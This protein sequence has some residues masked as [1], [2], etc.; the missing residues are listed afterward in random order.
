MFGLWARD[1]GT[2]AA[3]TAADEVPREDGEDER[4]PSNGRSICDRM[5]PEILVMRADIILELGI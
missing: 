1:F 4:D 5:S 3:R 2:R